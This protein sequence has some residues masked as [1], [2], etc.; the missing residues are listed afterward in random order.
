MVP[1]S[2]PI[3]DPVPE[4]ILG[5]FAVFVCRAYPPDQ[6]E[7]PTKLERKVCGVNNM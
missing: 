6:S 2:L 1:I 7:T 4:A 5:D 3:K